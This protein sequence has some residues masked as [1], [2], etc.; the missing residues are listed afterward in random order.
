MP[1][2]RLIML[3]VL[4]FQKLNILMFMELRKERRVLAW[5]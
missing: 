1:P 5:P 2:R 4:I 3:W